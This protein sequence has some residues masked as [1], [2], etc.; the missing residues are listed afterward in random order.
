MENWYNCK[1]S[2]AANQVM[3]KVLDYLTTNMKNLDKKYMSAASR[4][5]RNFQSWSQFQELEEQK[6]LQ[7][8]WF[9]VVDEALFCKEQLL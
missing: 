1:N 5:L 2:N 4:D 3:E 7:K 6:E 8:Q 9:A